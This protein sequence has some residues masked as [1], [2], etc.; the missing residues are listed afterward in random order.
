MF[1][2]IVELDKYITS[3]VTKRHLRR[4]GE[5]LIFDIILSKDYN[6]FD[7]HRRYVRNSPEYLHK[8]IDKYPRVGYNT[9]NNVYRAYYQWTTKE[10]I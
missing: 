8:K 6:D 9:Y 2:M 1:S 5:N 10:L 7:N 3:K 4:Y